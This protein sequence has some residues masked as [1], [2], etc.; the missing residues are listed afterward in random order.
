MAPG[1]MSFYYPLF[2]IWFITA[3]LVH[4]FIKSF[5]PPTQIHAP[6]SPPALPLIGHLHLIGSVLPK[7][8][9][10][11]AGRYGPLMEIRLGAS[12]CVVAS[13]ATAAKEIFKTHDLNFS[14][15][16]KFGSPEYFIYRGSRFVTAQYGDQWR[17]MKKLSMT[18]LLSVPQLDKFTNVCDEEKVKLVEPVLRLAKE[19]KKIGP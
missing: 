14:S 4:L 19:R 7:S 15:R 1:A 5:K 11:L 10:E 13:N 18:K 8:F 17:F 2:L 16:P 6:P 3:F 12:T 9:Q